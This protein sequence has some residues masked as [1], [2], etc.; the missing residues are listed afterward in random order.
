[1]ADTS[2]ALRVLPTALRSASATIAGHAA[3][4]AAPAGSLASSAELSGR[5]AVT[6]QAAFAE[7]GAALS[8]RLSAVSAGLVEMA[9]AFT[10]TEGANSAALA[11]IEPQQVG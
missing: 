2:G 3:R 7:F 4:V 11:S 1:M 5:A 10:A 8:G 9:G 6:A